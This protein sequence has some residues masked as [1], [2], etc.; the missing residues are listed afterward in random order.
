MKMNQIRVGLEKDIVSLVSNTSKEFE[1]KKEFCDFFECHRDTFTNW[2]GDHHTIPFNF[3]EKL[4]QFNNL[5]IW[6]F[7][8]GKELLG[9]SGGRGGRSSMIFSSK[10]TEGLANIFG[11]ILSDGHI[12]KDANRHVVNISQNIK[13][14][15]EVLSNDFEKTFKFRPIP[16]IRQSCGMFFLDI[17]SAPMRFILHNFW[18][19]PIGAKTN[20][21]IPKMVINSCNR[22]KFAFLSGIFEGEGTF[23]ANHKENRSVIHLEM[24]DLTF[25]TE[26]REML[27][28]L[29]F[30][31]TKISPHRKCFSFSLA[32]RKE[33][34]RFI[35]KI[36]PFSKHPKTEKFI[37]LYG[38]AA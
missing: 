18:N 33:I 21:S 25:I 8:E 24:N 22:I 32:R 14:V 26:V 1:S 19:L 35:R 27:I 11:W 13:P 16:K 2:F 3:L 17:N 30:H 29:G 36:K 9:W 7:L 38:V 20:F 23:T 4:C 12:T 15:L 37:R 5:D 34:K 10:I 28:D 31:P 6:E